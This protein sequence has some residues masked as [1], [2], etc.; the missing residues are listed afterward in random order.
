MISL[1]QTIIAWTGV[2]VAGAGAVASG[3]N[4]SRSKW[5]VLLTGAFAIETAVLVFFRLA[6]QFATSGVLGASTVGALF[7]M[8]SVVGVASRAAIVAGIAGLFSELSQRPS[9]TPA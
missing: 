9:T 1:A 3:M 7:L 2:L 8:A 5:A 6:V 4:I